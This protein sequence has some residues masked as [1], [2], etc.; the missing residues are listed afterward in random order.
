MKILTANQIKNCDTATIEKGI[1]SIS[2]MEKAATKCCD[3]MTD[4]FRNAEKFLIFCG[5]GNNGGDGFAIAR[6]LYEKGFD[7]EVFINKE[8]MK[9]SR[10]AEV[11]FKKIKAI[12]GITIKD[13]SEFDNRDNS[14]IIDAF[15]GYGLI[16]ELSYDF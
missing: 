12:S 16:R 2:L 11:N 13:Y 15:F 6:I 4:Y 7:I 8:N 14:V 10:D 5:N 9:F 1:K 3:W